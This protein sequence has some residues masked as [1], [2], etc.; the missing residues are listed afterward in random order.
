MPAVS[1][2]KRSACYL[3]ETAAVNI[4]NEEIVVKTGSGKLEPGTVLGYVTA[5]KKY[6]PHDDAGAG[7]AEVAAAILFHAVDATA[8][9]VKTVA[10]VRGPATIF[11]PELKLKAGIS[12]ANLKIAHDELRA[13]GMAVLPQHADL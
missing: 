6:V 8:S 5:D 1:M 2:T 7:G 12:A 4:V 9:D 11:G 13:K 3:G 10:T